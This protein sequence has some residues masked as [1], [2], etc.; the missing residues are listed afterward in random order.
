MTRRYVFAD[1]SRATR[2][3]GALVPDGVSVNSSIIRDGFGVSIS[4][5][6]L[7]GCYSYEF[8]PGVTDTH[9]LKISE[10]WETG[11]RV[12]ST[13]EPFDPTLAVAQ[14]RFI[15]TKDAITAWMREAKKGSRVVYFKGELA[16]YRADAPR[17]LVRLQAK[18]DNLPAGETLDT[19]E[20]IELAKIQRLLELLEAVQHLHQA[21]M[22]EMVQLRMTDGTGTVYYA[23]KR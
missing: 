13:Y 6:G 23:A 21:N 16:Q 11:S 5:C 15:E 18:A 8:G 14:V 17:R 1:I 3:L 12:E 7:A 4:V 9:L 22:I 20:R 2:V 10:Q 19:H